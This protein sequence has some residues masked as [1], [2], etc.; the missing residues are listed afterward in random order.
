MASLEE[1][2]SSRDPEL[3]K[4]KRGPFQQIITYIQKNLGRL[5]VRSAVKFDHGK[6]QR[7]QV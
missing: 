6:I 5:L 3:I 1:V 7:F 2:I 4:R